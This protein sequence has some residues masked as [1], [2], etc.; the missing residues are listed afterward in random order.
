MTG[1]VPDE[2]G[3]DPLLSVVVTVVAGGHAVAALLDALTVQVEPPPMEI[4]VPFDQSIA[5]VALLAGRFPSVRF[6]DLGQIGTTHPIM[7][8]AGQH[9]LY[10]R[11]R[12]AAL[13][14]ARGELVAILEDRGIPRPDWARTAVT[15]HRA[16]WAVIGGAIDP[17]PCTP[18]GWALYV[19]D[20]SRYGRPFESRAVEWVSDVNV[21][22]KR[23]A[24]ESTRA[25]WN[26]RF[27]EPL[28]HWDL[29]K[30]GETL[31][32]AAELVVV[33]HREPGT[34]ARTLAERFH[35]GRLFGHIR[36]REIGTGRRLAL[37]A[38]APLIPAVVLV[39]HCRIQLKQGRGGQVLRAVPLIGLLLGAWAAGELWGYVTRRP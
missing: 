22:Y 14:A 2:P 37:I 35:W 10:D 11:R 31:Y 1:E 32:L 29:L 18:L 25:I 5:D 36:A 26:E 15:L 13:S 17:A 39:R 28:V 23:R 33:H 6:L 21:V 30:R 7:S 19:C 38:A 3:S 24:I 12:S 4:L 8:A 16:P 34:L 20:Y 9:E 27:H